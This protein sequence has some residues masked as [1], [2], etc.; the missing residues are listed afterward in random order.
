MKE[1]IKQFDQKIKDKLLEYMRS[2]GPGGKKVI[3]AFMDEFEK[4]SDRSPA[5]DPTNLKNH[6]NFIL[7]HVKK[8]WDNSLQIDDDGNVSI[9]VCDDETLGFKIDRSKLK[10]HPSPI[11]WTVYLIRGIGGRYAFVNPET[12]FKKHG[13]PMPSRYYGGFLISKRAWMKEGWDKVVGSF[14][15]YE[16]PASGAPPIP[17]FKNVMRNIDINSIISEVIDDVR[18]DIP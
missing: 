4:L 16:H 1:L 6:M 5:D 17:F 13:H 10:H 8:T 9:G 2:D 7:S 14:E 11:V 18:V 12:Y 15:A 3:L